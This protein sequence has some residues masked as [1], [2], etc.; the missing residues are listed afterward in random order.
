[1]AAAEDEAGRRGMTLLVLDTELDSL[2]DTLYP[3]LG[4]QSSG[5]IP[6]YAAGPDGRLHPTVIYFKK[7][8]E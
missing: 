1:M 7:L 5:E 6:D 3:K 2:A 8:G 4:Y